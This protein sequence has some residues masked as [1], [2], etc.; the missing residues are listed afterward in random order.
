REAAAAALSQARAAYGRPLEDRTAIGFA[1]WGMA[2]RWAGRILAAFGDAADVERLTSDKAL[3]NAPDDLLIAARIEQRLGTIGH[4][5]VLAL[6]D[7]DRSDRAAAA[8]V[9]LYQA[10]VPHA[11]D[12]LS[13]LLAEPPPSDSDIWYRALLA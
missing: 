13:V 7:L 12:R 11:E 5:R 1:R 9:L 2:H 10:D 6:A 4:G 3:Y 8:A